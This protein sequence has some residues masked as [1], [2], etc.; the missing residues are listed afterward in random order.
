MFVNNSAR[1][2]QVIAAVVLAAIAIPALANPIVTRAMWK[3][4]PDRARLAR[5]ILSEPGVTYLNYHVSGVR[6]SATA[7]HNM[8][9]TA[10]GRSAQRSYYG[11]APGGTCRLDPRMLRAIY[12][13][14]REGHTFRITELAGGSHSI[15]SRHYAGLGFDIDFLDGRKI[16]YGHP[17]YRKFMKRC[18]ELGA[19]EVLGPGSRGHS[20][21]VHVAWPRD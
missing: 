14:A 20:T 1:L 16:G 10:Q 13:L 7:K 3:E 8:Q 4:R 5:L 12:Q 2:P 9:Q 6:D 11:N 17:T 21:H 15:R 18:R 19:T